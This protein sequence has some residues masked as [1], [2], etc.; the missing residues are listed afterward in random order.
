MAE[1]LKLTIHANATTTPKIRAYIQASS[2]PV[3]ELARELAVSETTIRR[4]RSRNNVA[5]RDSRPRRVASSLSPRDTA[6]VIA[7]KASAGLTL[8]ELLIVARKELG[9]RVSRS[10]LRRCL[11]RHGL[12]LRDP[13][14]ASTWTRAEVRLNDEGSGPSL[15]FCVEWVRVAS[16]QEGEAVFSAVVAVQRETGMVELLRCNDGPSVEILQKLIVRITE[17]CP[18][19]GRV[20]LRIGPKLRPML[21]LDD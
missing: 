7:L 14:V 2:K 11:Q 17:Q 18:R 9:L 1:Q 4:W 19:L 13:A 21:A 3:A 15:E 20:R 6:I 5:D 8:D 10:A 12:S 16:E